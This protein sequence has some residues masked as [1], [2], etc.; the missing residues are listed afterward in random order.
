MV[1][2]AVFQYFTTKMRVFMFFLWPFY[3]YNLMVCDNNYNKAHWTYYLIINM[4]CIRGWPQRQSLASAFFK[5]WGS[6]PG[7][8]PLAQRLTL[9]SEAETG[10]R[11]CGWPQTLASVSRV[12]LSFGHAKLTSASG[13]RPR[14]RAVYASLPPPA[15]L[16]ESGRKSS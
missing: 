15:S 4:S 7:P 12:Y 11:G 10:L 9:A 14:S 13:R 8:P 6:R 1:S 2:R 3:I 5:A 16:K